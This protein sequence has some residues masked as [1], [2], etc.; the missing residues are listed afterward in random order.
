MITRNP[1]G[2][3]F[4]IGT[5]LESTLMVGFRAVVTRYAW[6]GQC[7][8]YG[9]SFTREEIETGK[10]H[11]IRREAIEI[12]YGLIEIDSKAPGSLLDALEPLNPGG[13]Q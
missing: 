10:C 13:A 8:C 6:D 2:L 1:F 7:W 12:E 9:L 4:E 11:Y 3:R 5:L